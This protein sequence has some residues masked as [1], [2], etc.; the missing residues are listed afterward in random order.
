MFGRVE[1]TTARFFAQYCQLTRHDSRAF[2]IIFSPKDGCK[3]PLPLIFV[4]IRTQQIA[5]REDDALFAIRQNGGRGI[6]SARSHGNRSRSNVAVAAH[7]RSSAC[8]VISKYE[9]RQS[10]AIR[11]G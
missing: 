7:E 8:R 11:R 3:T 6:I 2:K 5:V 9:S 1:P 4:V 10:P